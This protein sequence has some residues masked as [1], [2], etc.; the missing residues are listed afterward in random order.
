M[1]IG[2]IAASAVAALLAGAPSA[3]AQG[4]PLPLAGSLPTSETTVATGG[5][6]TAA[7][8]P[9]SHTRQRIVTDVHGTP[10]QADQYAAYYD[11]DGSIVL[12]KRTLPNGAWTTHDTGFQLTLPTDPH[13]IPALGID[14]QGHIHLIYNTAIDASGGMKYARSTVA[15]DITS[16]VSKSEWDTGTGTYVWLFKLRGEL[17]A[18]YFRGRIYSGGVNYGN[19]FLRRWSV[20]AQRWERPTWSPTWQNRPLVH[21]DVNQNDYP[22]YAKWAMYYSIHPDEVDGSI[23]L[24]WTWV[25]YNATTGSG[26]TRDLSYAVSYD[27]GASWRTAG[28]LSLGL[29]IIKEQSVASVLFPGLST[30]CINGFA[31][32]GAGRRHI[33]Y[34]RPDDG[35]HVDGSQEVW[36]YRH[37]WF[38]GAVLQDQAVT[39][40]STAVGNPCHA[41]A[42]RSAFDL[43]PDGDGVAGVLR[44]RTSDPW[45]LWRSQ[46]PFTS[47][48]FTS[49]GSTARGHQQP[50]VD[51][52]RWRHDRT[53]DLLNTHLLHSPFQVS[54]NVTV[55]STPVP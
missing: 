23:N 35:V 36:N 54:P 18:S 6:T 5:Y 21:G 43:V 30:T 49:L 32:D 44:P 17:Y 19:I 2:A 51:H 22:L 24:V 25:P 52:V 38:D 15:R 1:R 39:S 3:G 33:G 31:R 16:V 10:A 29:P 42:S 47:Q 40:F 46:P 14:R 55:S 9:A 26:S 45:L 34:L 48:T 28:G 41:D 13:Q 8:N 53:L 37:A 27:G 12:A 20:A 50:L 7:H 4:D 11:G